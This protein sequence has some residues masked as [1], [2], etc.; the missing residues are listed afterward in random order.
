MEFYLPY[1]T[2]KWIIIGGK[3]RIKISL[4]FVLIWSTE[5]FLKRLIIKNEQVYKF[6][7]YYTVCIHS[8]ETSD[9]LQYDNIS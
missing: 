8:Q 7:Y 6:Y 4:V 5:R 9:L 3:T 2:S 1:F